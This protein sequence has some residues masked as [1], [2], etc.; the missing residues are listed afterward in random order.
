MTPEAFDA[1]IKT[2]IGSN[3]TLVK[4]AGLSPTQ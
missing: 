2:E 1:Y 3:A 4:A